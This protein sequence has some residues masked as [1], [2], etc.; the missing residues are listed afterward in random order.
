[1]GVALHLAGP[2]QESPEMTAFPPDEF[3][4]LQKADLCH[5][6]AGIRFDPPE[7][8]RTA[9]RRE[10]MATS[11]IPQEAERMAHRE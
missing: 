11:C 5:L 4:E 8:I 6:D 7:K 3:P 9:P 10:A 2:L 1:M